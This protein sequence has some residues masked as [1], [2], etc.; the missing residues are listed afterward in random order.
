MYLYCIYLS[1]YIYK[2][3]HCTYITFIRRD[4]YKTLEGTESPLVFRIVR[5]NTKVLNLNIIPENLPWS[6]YKTIIHWTLYLWKSCGKNMYYFNRVNTAYEILWSRCY[7]IVGTH[8]LC[9]PDWKCLSY[10]KTWHLITISNIT[11]CEKKSGLSNLIPGLIT[12]CSI[13]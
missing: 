1:I 9:K 2:Y 7:G 13:L 8:L 3:V 5:D 4:L 6:H 11:K 12:E 10:L